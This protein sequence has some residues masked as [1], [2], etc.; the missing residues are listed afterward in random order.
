LNEFGSL[1]NDF[2]STE[3][4]SFFSQLA[5]LVYAQRPVHPLHILRPEILKKN[6]SAFLSGFSGTVMYAVKSNP[7]PDVI[8]SLYEAGIRYFDAASI[9]EVRLVRRVA[10]SAHIHFMHTVKSREAIREAYFDHQVRV[11]VI[12]TIDELHKIVHET[13]LANDL[14]IFVRLAL[15]KNQEA[16]VDFSAKFG[17]TPKGAAF[18]LHEARLVCSKLGIMFHPGTQSSNPDVFF[19]G[20][21]VVRDVL[22]R[23]SG[24]TVDCLDVGGGFP[25]PYPQRI[26][27][28]LS[29]FF[30]VIERGIREFEL[31]NL[32]LYCEPGRALVAEAG[33][34][35]CRVEQ[36]KDKALYLNDGIYGGLVEAAK[37]QGALS[38]PVL[39]IAQDPSSP[40]TPEDTELSP[41]RFC[42]PTCDSL[43]MMKGP[44]YLPQ[45]I[46]E[47]DWIVVGL[48]GA[49]SNACRTD[50]NGFGQHRFLSVD[51]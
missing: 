17:A 24:I 4:R 37:W 13:E 50:F 7:H 11:F 35:V 25:A 15:P 40:H 19:K 46:G 2:L 28:P 22:N 51:F 8:H 47:G 26:I 3:N 21:G 48:T 23:C 20:L 32:E 18:L 39:H 30:D 41:F 34:L 6:A 14:T 10:P 36:R 9:E 27:P 12:D 29:T 5:D 42:G 43:D 44:F 1:N 38:F 45:Q 16:N 33:L 31:Q 49:Y